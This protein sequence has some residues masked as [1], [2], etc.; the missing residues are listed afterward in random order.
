VQKLTIIINVFNEH[1]ANIARRLRYMGKKVII[2]SIMSPVPVLDFDWADT[3]LC[4]YSYSD[5]SFQALFAALNGEIE[6]EGT[7]PLDQI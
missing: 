6:C 4:G 1:T 3:I 7:I 2:L 5:F